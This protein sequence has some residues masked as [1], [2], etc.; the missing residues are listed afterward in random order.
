MSKNA[1]SKNVNVN[2]TNNKQT[3][4][5][6]SKDKVE[7]KNGIV[8]INFSKFKHEVENKIF[9]KK[10]KTD[11]NTLYNYENNDIK[12][13]EIN[14]PKGKSF[15]RKM[16]ADLEK[17]ANNIGFAYQREETENLLEEIKSFDNWYKKNFL[18]NNYKIDSLSNA[19]EEK[20]KFKD[21]LFMLQVINDI[22]SNA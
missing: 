8:K 11:R 14:L 17:F 9:E 12:K 19:N 7:I 22:K 1:S 16:R 2:T 13:E 15:R 3:I 18:L 4:F 5:A 20:S 6:D 10:S 21:I